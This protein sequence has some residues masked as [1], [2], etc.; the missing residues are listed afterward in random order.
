[1]ITKPT[2]CTDHSATII[3][4]IITNS[5]LT[6]YESCIITSGVSDHFPVIFFLQAAKP[7]ESKKTI[8]SRD[9][10]ESNLLK[11][12]QSLHSLRWG[13][14]L[15]EEDP[16]MAYNVFSDLFFNLYNLH[17]PLREIKFHKNF[18]VKEP[19][20]SKGLLIS[21]KEKI[22][23]SSLAA[24]NPTQLLKSNYKKYRNIF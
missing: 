17:F 13:L 23:L 10:S 4:H 16:Q 11:F 24:K 1:V 20:M 6:N 15:E 5:Q 7:H 19:R 18:H 22:R 9:F 3:D 14:V 8:F 2:R 12:E 21:R